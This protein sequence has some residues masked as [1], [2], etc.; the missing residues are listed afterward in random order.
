MW[1]IKGRGV[2][3]LAFGVD[4][5]DGLGPLAQAWIFGLGVNQ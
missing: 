1:R 3:A 5:F 4:E 2:G